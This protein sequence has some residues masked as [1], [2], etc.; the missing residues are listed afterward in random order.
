MGLR[1]KAESA[2]IVEDKNIYL[3][4]PKK[5]LKLCANII[6]LGDVRFEEELKEIDGILDEFVKISQKD[7][8][9]MGV[10]TY[11]DLE[12]LRDDIVNIFNFPMLE[13]SY[14]VA[15]GGSFSAG[16]STFLNRVLGLKDILPTD[17]NPTTS[18]PAYIVNGSSE[19]FFAL[20]N[21][22]NVIKLDREAIG[23]ISHAF[24]KKY[25]VSFSHIIKFL[26]I[27]QSG[28]KYENI[29]F[30]DTPGYSKSENQKES[31]DENIAREHLRNTDFLIWLVDSH[32]HMSGSDLEFIKSLD[33][34]HP[35]LVVLNKA[36]KRT[37][38]EIDD[39]V[40]NMKKSLK[41]SGIS[42]YDVVGYSSLKDL[43]Y[44]KSKNVIKSYLSTISKAKNGTKI[45]KNVNSVFKRYIDYYDSKLFEYRTTRV[46][47]S[48]M[49]MKDVISDETYLKEIDRLNKKRV[50]Q[51]KDIES[52]KKEVLKLQKRLEDVILKIL[53]DCGVNIVDFKQDYIFDETL[54]GTKKRGNNSFRFDANLQLR[55]EN[56]LLKF[57]DLKSIEAIVYKIS[58]IGVFIKIP[59]IKND[60]M[61]SKSKIKK[62]SGGLSAEEIFKDGDRVIVQI[63]DSKKC[64]V[65]KG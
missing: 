64:V 22:N 63:V 7:S 29:V 25:S 51:I 60:I 58:S 54:Y 39:M 11:K 31:S 45:V 36:D 4:E 23:A 53:V 9:E 49:M 1:Q 56:E 3:S 48:E 30:L 37:Q 16:K 19:N 13:N 52:S 42:F 26:F 57:K 27:E 33:L 14:T 47:L 28:L 61:L 65:I 41:S 12:N 34:A 2:K 38:K 40:E 6:S 43:E 46:V 50:K 62:D 35:I 8:N 5:G 20:N 10:K 21:F 44:S 15:V 17:T 32:S 18:I 24:N 59:G 55:D